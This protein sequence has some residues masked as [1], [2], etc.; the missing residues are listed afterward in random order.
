MI[1][2]PGLAIPWFCALLWDV[3]IFVLTLAKTFR[4][5]RALRLRFGADTLLFLLV[6]DGALATYT[7]NLRHESFTGSYYF[8]WVFRWGLE[9]GTTQA[10][11]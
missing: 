1:P 2:S 8:V 11:L 3:T 7:S 4:E 6:R 5:T 10:I 9:D